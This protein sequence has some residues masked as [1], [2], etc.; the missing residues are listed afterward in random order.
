MKLLQK[1]AFWSLFSANQNAVFVINHYLVY[2]A[3]LFIYFGVRM[4]SD[5]YNS[6]F[7]GCP[8]LLTETSKPFPA[9]LENVRQ[10]HQHRCQ[11]VLVKYFHRKFS[12]IS[13]EILIIFVKI[14]CCKSEIYY[15]YEQNCTS[16]PEILL[17]ICTE[18]FYFSILLPGRQIYFLGLLPGLMRSKGKP[19]C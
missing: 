7:Y 3:I 6:Q 4:Y 5:I 19:G 17:M 8:F 10:H 14:V 9:V 18:S 15:H 1:F 12:H 2:T 16:L 11:E 13:H